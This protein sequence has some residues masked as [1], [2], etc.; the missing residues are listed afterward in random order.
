MTGGHA[1]DNIIGDFS[2]GSAIAKLEIVDPYVLALL[3]N[4]GHDGLASKDVLKVG[5]LAGDVESIQYTI[6][7]L[8]KRKS[9]VNYFN[10]NISRSTIQTR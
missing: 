8:M 10:D 3:T 5:A 1:H 7:L 9:G 6:Q 2:G 4:H